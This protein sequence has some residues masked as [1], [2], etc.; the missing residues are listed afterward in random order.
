M[1]G[2][3]AAISLDKI[4]I[5]KKRTA[6]I[7]ELQ[8]WYNHLTA[9]KLCLLPK[10]GFSSFGAAAVY[11][12]LKILSK[13]GIV[14]EIRSNSKIRFDGNVKLHYHLQCTDCGRLVNLGKQYIRNK[15]SDTIAYITDHKDERF[16]TSCKPEFSGICPDRIKNNQYSMEE[17]DGT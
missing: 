14:N 9:E 1:E 3:I 10:N 12:N 5:T 4:K 2:K 7:N 8:R 11:R 13:I 6:I 16:I 17:Y 15:I